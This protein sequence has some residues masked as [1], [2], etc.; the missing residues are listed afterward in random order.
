MTSTTLWHSSRGAW[1]A[2][3]ARIVILITDRIDAHPRRGV[4]VYYIPS[5][6]DGDYLASSA[7]QL[8]NN[9]KHFLV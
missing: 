5:R 4:C 2:G 9:I 6:A 1:G 3:W 8:Y 7:R